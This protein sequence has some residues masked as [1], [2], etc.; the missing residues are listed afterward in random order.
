MI[1]EKKNIHF[2]GIGG[3]GMSAIALVLLKM[4]Y[5]VSGSDLG[6]SNLTEKLTREGAVIN[7]GHTHCNVPTATEVVVYSSSINDSNPEIQEAGKR[8]LL[9]V[10]RAEVLAEL[11]N[12]KKGI[13]VTGTHGKTTTSSLISVMLENCGLDPTAMI[14]G[15]V[16]LF[17]GNSKYGKGEYVVAEADESDGSFL[18]LKPLYSVITNLEMEHIDYYK[19]LE[20]AINSYAAFANNTKKRGCLFYNAEDKNIARSLKSYSGNKESF[21]FS[22]NADIYPHEILMNE[23]YTSYVC[24]YKN[25]IIGRVSLRIPGRHNVLNS[26]AAMLVGF[27]LGLSFENICRSIQ[28]FTGTKRRFHLRA[29]VD[30]VMLIDDY[31]HHP[32]EIRAVLDACR[33]W[34]DRRVVVVFQPHRYTRTKYLAE[35]FGRCFK[36]ADKLIL[37]D[38]YAASEEPIEGVS[39]KNIYDRVKLHGLNDVMMMNKEKITEHIM[40]MKR[41]GDMIVILGAGDIKEVSDELS[42]KLNKR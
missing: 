13:A 36:G 38:I 21:G 6:S 30:G 18:Y 7:F 10:K 37:T 40:D 27:K 26:L 8:N 31:A 33:N 12:A 16:E 4:G 41:S 1:L 28:D 3:I 9:I 22:K 35:E 5:K 32:T 19:T 14:G 39:V 29:D 20:D 11:L 24:V 34:K 2:I 15:E 23:F 25:E 17:G 42:E